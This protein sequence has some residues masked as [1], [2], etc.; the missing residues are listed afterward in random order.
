M[1]RRTFQVGAMTLPDHAC[2]SVE[3]TKATTTML[4]SAFGLTDV[5]VQD[6]G[7][8]GKR[9]RTNEMPESSVIHTTDGLYVTIS[10]SAQKGANQ[11]WLDG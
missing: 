5:N 4:V 7:R 3:T 10:S 8:Q 11:K 9:F 2:A 1:M 6:F